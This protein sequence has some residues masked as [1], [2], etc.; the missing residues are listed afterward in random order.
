MATRAGRPIMAFTGAR[1]YSLL[2]ASLAETSDMVGSLL[3][4]GNAGPAESAD[5]WIPHLVRRLNECTGTQVRVRIDA[6]FAYN[7][8][9]E[10]L[11]DRDIEYLGRLRSQTG[12][13]KLVAPHLERPPGRLP[14]QPREWCYDLEYQAGSWPAPRRVL[15][16]VQERPDEL[17]HA[18]LVT[19]LSKFDWPPENVLALYPRRGSAE[20][21]IGEVKLAL[22]VHLSSTD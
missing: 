22:G 10:A 21:S 6:G 4:E 7:A 11:E 9:L 14:E 2:I 17:L 20:V 16:V 8:T 5:A 19:N 13:Q 18:F 1:T 3:R 15:L 12:L